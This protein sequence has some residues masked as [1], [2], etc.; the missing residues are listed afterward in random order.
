MM[1]SCYV[2]HVTK[3]SKIAIFSWKLGICCLAY[4]LFMYSAIVLQIMNCYI[5]QIKFISKLPYSVGFHHVAVIFHNFTAHTTFLKSCKSHKINCCFSMTI[6]YK[7]SALSCNQR[8]HMTRSS[9]ILW[10]RIIISTFHN[11]VG[12]LYCRYSCCCINMVN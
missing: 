7:N 12:T 2:I 8:K 1:L 4:M 5:F 11:C 6:S 10:F 3:Y 9:E